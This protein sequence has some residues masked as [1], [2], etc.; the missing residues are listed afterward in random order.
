M[1]STLSKGE[2]ADLLGIPKSQIRF[3]EQ[4]GLLNPKKEKNGYASYDYEELDQL[5]LILI[6]KELGM[7]IAE[8]KKVMDNESFDY[9]FYLNQSLTRVE[10]EIEDAKRRRQM[11]KQRLLQYTQ[12][13]AS[14]YK[15][16]TFDERRLY[17]MGKDYDKELTLREIYELVKENNIVYLDY[18]YE[19]CESYDLNHHYFGFIYNGDRHNDL[20]E[21]RMI[22]KGRYFTYQFMRYEEEDIEIYKEKMKEEALKRGIKLSGYYIFL[23]YY[24]YKFYTSDKVLGRLQYLIE[25]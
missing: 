1:K 23:D 15:V 4:K 20:I 25:D 8:M 2:V 18:E 10:K 13:K 17:V 12:D 14:V 7:S 24:Y 9:A 22:P 6:F 19:L 3:Y 16:L 21:Y 5:E 11:I